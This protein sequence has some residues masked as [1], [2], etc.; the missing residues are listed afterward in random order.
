MTLAFWFAIHL[1]NDE[2]CNHMIRRMP[3]LRKIVVSIL[4]KQNQLKEGSMYMK[5]S[6]LKKENS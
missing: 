3:F 1:E 5:K 2:M 6:S 4:K